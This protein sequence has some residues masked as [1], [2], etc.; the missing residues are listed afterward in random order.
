MGGVEDAGV[1]PVGPGSIR[2][3][4]RER[5]MR[6][7][8]LPTSISSG[9]PCLT[10]MRRRAAAGGVG[11]GSSPRVDLDPEKKEQRESRWGVKQ[12]G[13]LVSP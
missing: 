11:R 8:V 12:M 1:D 7:G 9:Q 3:T 2:G 13:V 4:R 5:R 10:A 6:G